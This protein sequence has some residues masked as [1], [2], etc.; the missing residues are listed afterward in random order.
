MNL[1]SQPAE[2]ITSEL[3]MMGKVES[4]SMVGW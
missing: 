1:L 2:W 4:I 3:V